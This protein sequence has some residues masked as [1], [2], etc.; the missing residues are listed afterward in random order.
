M[1]LTGTAPPGTPVLVNPLVRRSS[2]V[3]NGS[4]R[5]ITDPFAWEVSP[6]PAILIAATILDAIW[7]AVSVLRIEIG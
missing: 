6:K 4:F 1:K 2:T 3:P 5:V 7:A